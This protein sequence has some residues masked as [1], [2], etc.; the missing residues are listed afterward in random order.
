MS[1]IFFC[2]PIATFFV[3]CFKEDVI[4]LSLFPPPP[5][6]KSAQAYATFFSGH[7]FHAVIMKTLKQQGALAMIKIQTTLLTKL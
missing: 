6:E 4:A 7:L 3:E 5:V 2:L 1:Q